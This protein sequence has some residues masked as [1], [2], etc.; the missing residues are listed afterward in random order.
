MARIGLSQPY[1]A[2]YTYDA[3]AG[4]VAL[5]GWKKIGKAVN[6]T[7]EAGEAEGDALRADNADAETVSAFVSGS[8]TIT[9]DDLR[10]DVNAFI[11]GV[12]PRADGAIVQTAKDRAPHLAFAGVVKHQINNEVKYQAVLLHKIQFGGSAFDVQTEQEPIEFQTP[13]LPFT[14]YRDDTA[15]EAYRTLRWFDSEADA[16]AWFTAITAFPE[17]VTAGG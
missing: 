12:E 13:E 11:Y 16:V 9:L 10:Q 5:T 7:L 6:M 3:E 4:T 8:G 17:T 1:A 14:Y 15:D 2:K